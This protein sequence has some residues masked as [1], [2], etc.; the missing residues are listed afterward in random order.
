MR[1]DYRVKMRSI[2]VGAIFN[3]DQLQNRAD[4]HPPTRL[5]AT[6]AANLLPRRG[7]TIRMR[8]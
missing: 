3:R 2:L 4:A 1:Y 6:I 7:R 8:L 5:L